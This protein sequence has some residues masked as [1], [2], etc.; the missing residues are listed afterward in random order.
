MS[1][2]VNPYKPADYGKVAVMM[3][4]LS[5][6]RD[7][8]LQS[9]GAVL[10]ALERLGIDTHALDVQQDVMQQ[11][12]AGQ[13][14]RVFIALHGRGGEDGL[15][16][17]ALD[18]LGLPYTGSPVIG[19]ALAMDKVRTKKIWQ[20]SGI[21]TPGFAE[22]HA[23]SNWRSV[24]EQLGLPLMVKPVHEG[25]SFGASRVNR[26]EDLE[27]AW[28]QAVEYDDRVMAEQWITGGEY[29]VPL[30]DKEI[31][32]MIKLETPREFYDYRAKY[33]DDTT[34]YICPCGLT[35]DAEKK[36]GEMASKAFMS[37]G[38]T[39][40]G[41]VDVLLDEDKRPW[42]IEVNTIPGLTSHSLV[43]MAAKQAG[44]DFDELVLRILNTS[45]DDTGR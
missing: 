27:A 39:G 34:Q 12:I 3:G 36:I 1:D 2:Y 22:L 40:W 45:F 37:L 6:E 8:S 44:T 33:E 15:M 10:A 41:R 32:P 26:Y 4:G 17:G 25:S 13:Y 20:S 5:A 35:D 14:D 38:C 30:L 16:Q 11:V 24:C 18:T 29:T 28:R 43:P 23:G 7:I 42:L 9:G 19:S 31:L 21:P